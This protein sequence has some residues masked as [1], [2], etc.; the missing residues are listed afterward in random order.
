MIYSNASGRHLDQPDLR[1]VFDAAAELNLPLY[2]HPTDP[3]FAP[4]LVAYALI[5]S[6]RFL[7]DI[8]LSHT[9]SLISHFAARIDYDSECFGLGP[10]SLSIPAIEHMKLTYT[11]RSCVS[12]PAMAM[13]SE[14]FCPEHMVFGRDY[15]LWDPARNVDARWATELSESVSESLTHCAPDEL[16]RLAAPAAQQV[17]AS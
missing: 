1:H 9:V 17:A 7:F 16:F 2:I 3:L 12:P 14:F 11:D 10:G 13:S 5:S 15:P 4:T 8:E 6:A